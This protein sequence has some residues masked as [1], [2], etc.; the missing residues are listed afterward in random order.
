MIPNIEVMLDFLKIKYFSKCVDKVMEWKRYSDYKQALKVHGNPSTPSSKPLTKE[1][2]FSFQRK[3]S[4]ELEKGEDSG[5]PQ[6]RKY[7][8]NIDTSPKS[9]QSRPSKIKIAGYEIDTD[10]FKPRPRSESEEGGDEK[11]PKES[12]VK[13]EGLSELVSEP[14]E[15]TAENILDTSNIHVTLK[16]KSW[17]TYVLK[18]CPAF[19]E[20]EFR[21][22]WLF[23]SE[24]LSDN[25]K[26][27]NKRIPI[28]YF[29]VKLTK[30]NFSYQSKEG[31]ADLNFSSFKILDVSRQDSALK[32][33]LHGSSVYY[34]AVGSNSNMPKQSQFGHLNATL[35]NKMELF[36]SIKMDKSYFSSALKPVDLKR[37]PSTDPEE[38]LIF[39]SA[40]SDFTKEFLSIRE[41]R[42][43]IIDWEL[44]PKREH[45][46]V[47][48]ILK[49]NKRTN[50]D[51]Y[52]S[53]K[54]KKSS[55]STLKYLEDSIIHS[56]LN[57]GLVGEDIKPG[58][59][60]PKMFFGAKFQMKNG[61]LLGTMTFPSIYVNF[62]AGIINDINNL[63]HHASDSYNLSNLWYFE[64]NQNLIK[65]WEEELR[66]STVTNNSKSRE[67][68]AADEEKI[69]K[70]IEEYYKT[71][72]IQIEMSIG[73]ASVKVAINIESP[74]KENSCH[75][76]CGFSSL[77]SPD[78]QGYCPIFQKEFVIIELS[79]IGVRF[80]KTPYS[81]QGDHQKNL[82][83]LCHILFG[84]LGV[85]IPVFNKQIAVENQV[86]LSKVFSLTPSENKDNYV[87]PSILIKF[88]EACDKP[89]SRSGSL[90]DEGEEQEILKEKPFKQFEIH[91]EEKMT[92]IKLFPEN[93]EIG[94]R[95]GHYQKH[96]N[97]FV[98]PDLNYFKLLEK[99]SFNTV[100]VALPSV[101]VYL[102]KQQIAFLHEF[103]ENL[104][105]SIT[106]VN[107][108]LMQVLE[109]EKKFFQKIIE[110]QFKK[111]EPTPQ[112]ISVYIDEINTFVF[113]DDHYI[114]CCKNLLDQRKKKVNP[115]DLTASSIQLDAS[116]TEESTNQS[117]SSHALQGI[118]C[119]FL[120]REFLRCAK[121]QI[122]LII[123][124][125][126]S[127]I[128]KNPDNGLLVTHLE[129]YDLLLFDRNQETAKFGTFMKAEPFEEKKEIIDGMEESGYALIYKQSHYNA[130]EKPLKETKSLKE[131]DY[132][133]DAQFQALTSIF[134]SNFRVFDYKNKNVLSLGIFAHSDKG[135]TKID[136]DIR[137]AD[138]NFRSDFKLEFVDTLKDLTSSL[139]STKANNTKNIPK[140]S[141]E[142]F[143][144]MSSM[145]KREAIDSNVVVLKINVDSI[146]IDINPYYT[147]DYLREYGTLHNIDVRGLEEKKRDFRFYSGTRS[148]IALES[149]GIR[150]SKQGKK[151]FGFDLLEISSLDLFMR[152]SSFSPSSIENT[153]IL[154]STNPE[155]SLFDKEYEQIKTIYGF[156]SHPIFINNFNM[157]SES[158]DHNSLNI[159][160]ENII[161]DVHAD[162]IPT[163]QKHMHIIEYL[164]NTKSKEKA[165]EMKKNKGM[166]LHRIP[167]EEYKSKSHD[168]KK[169][170][171]CQ[172]V[173]NEEDYDIDHNYFG[174]YKEI[175]AV[176]DEEDQ[177]VVRIIENE[178][179]SKKINGS[180]EL[181]ESLMSST[182]T[183]SYVSS[184]LG[185]FW[186]EETIHEFTVVDQFPSKKINIR[187]GEIILKIFESYEFDPN[188]NIIE[189]HVPGEKD[190][191]LVTQKE[192]TAECI[193]LYIENT[194]A[195]WSSFTKN[196]NLKTNALWRTSCTIDNIEILDGLSSAKTKQGNKL[197]SK[198]KRDDRM[199]NMKSNLEQ[200]NKYRNR[201]YP[202]I[203]NM[204]DIIIECYEQ[205][206]SPKQDLRVFIGLHPVKIYLRKPHYNFFNLFMAK[207]N[208]KMGVSSENVNPV[209][210]K[211]EAPKIKKPQS[212]NVF[213]PIFFIAPF[214]LKMNVNLDI[215]VINIDLFKDS[216]LC[217][218]SFI[219][220]GAEDTT[221]LKK[222]LAAFYQ[223]QV[224]KQI[225][226][227]VKDLPVLRNINN[228]STATFNLFYSPYIHYKE[229]GNVL[230]GLKDGVTGFIGS[231]ANESLNFLDFVATTVDNVAN[232][233]G[234]KGK[235]NIT[236]SKL[237][238]KI[239]GQ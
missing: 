179:K 176:E 24:V 236:S 20:N 197:F 161:I 156:K 74:K 232:A 218:K 39:K 173:R 187:V 27:F 186:D 114:Q 65:K 10:Y 147:Y 228:I 102:S 122:H 109:E 225:S 33:K 15:L 210:K 237:I 191:S 227:F 14:V 193:T 185:C 181:A 54:D 169:N 67:L 92:D 150:L 8:E 153:L 152:N 85:Y 90:I 46:C 166:N 94:N 108:K 196:P 91:F 48:V 59:H 9:T 45:F 167:E 119:V 205:K 98:A 195:C 219:F 157:K 151:R 43:P 51:P 44:D 239:T 52:A 168:D 37:V 118:R 113:K 209:E 141:I 76:F 221:Q 55:Q 95:Y 26:S 72:Q 184:S 171:G 136:I 234:I 83:G 101:N 199:E 149:L 125:I 203:N 140:E 60:D 13:I 79:Q 235:V 128:Y 224:R 70:V 58:E 160:L 146:I 47:N 104:N 174:S 211:P 142:N 53:Y 112:L 49:F 217:F 88:Y 61:K 97:K 158:G 229:G 162:T 77:F 172:I 6:S 143:S 86:F 18:S 23:G 123:K 214:E 62:Y 111:A 17:Y 139:E 154:R 226:K 2:R 192:E 68:T 89:R 120:H 115:I 189:L 190:K 131:F 137:L 100:K 148:L 25:Q 28:N 31:T 78:P 127:V 82:A 233:T 177:D 134:D 12:E 208:E 22:V 198:L 124:E 194:K 231:I 220:R 80:L 117:F 63:L 230:G 183:V 126:D 36:Q 135:T 129:I 212:S 133:R 30:L 29:Q 7:S 69:N 35:W 180:Q 188:S 64:E 116:M 56:P 87:L 201:G 21:R 182:S 81:S 110:K 178:D 204:F 42:K 34:S 84:D 1:R 175:E 215:S 130:H 38:S 216:L 213:F 170:T 163:I 200:V 71:Q 145:E 223:K 5:M 75:C 144:P 107:T 222:E 96:M 57:N 99:D 41:V 103:T 132:F 4:F 155:L 73:I 138:L 164:L 19:L 238:G 105:S 66:D 207:M 165:N 40:K 206:F 32:I 50:F 121:S 106:E 11:K 16:I 3:E 202:P 159:N 93:G